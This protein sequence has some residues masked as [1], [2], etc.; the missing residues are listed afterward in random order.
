MLGGELG[1]TARGRRRK[2]RGGC[3]QVGPGRQREGDASWV[4]LF[5]GR[6]NREAGLLA[7]AACGVRR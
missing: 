5:A 4:E 2:V 6:E 1:R 3:R 7:L